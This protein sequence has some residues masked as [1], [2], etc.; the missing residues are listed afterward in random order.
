M[1]VKIGYSW[2]TPLP[3]QPILIQFSLEE[4]DQI[5]SMIE[6]GKN[7]YCKF[8][9]VDP[10]YPTDREREQWILRDVLD[11]NNLEK[12]APQELLPEQPLEKP[13]TRR[14]KQV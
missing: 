4:L 8:A 6:S 12:V 14:K 10:L 13:K 3:G 5:K 2:F 1:L 7:I 11:S 9:T